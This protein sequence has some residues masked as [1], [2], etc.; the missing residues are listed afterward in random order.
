MSLLVK[1]IQEHELNYGFLYHI[2]T[3]YPHGICVGQHNMMITEYRAN[4]LFRMIIALIQ[5]LFI[6]YILFIGND[7]TGSTFLVGA[8]I[9]SHTLV[10]QRLHISR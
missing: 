4:P 6:A 9:L 3:T 1:N 7:P 10:L 8:H 5:L 2:R